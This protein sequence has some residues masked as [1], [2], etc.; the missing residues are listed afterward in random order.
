MS[1]PD[2]KPP[3]PSNEPSLHAAPKRAHLTFIMMWPDGDWA[4]K[5]EGTEVPRE[6]YRRVYG[7]RTAIPPGVSE[8]ATGLSI[9]R[10]QRQGGG[11]TPKALPGG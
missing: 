11:R 5:Q 6:K 3:D 4:G 10:S 2:E 1:T 7:I 9:F 8:T